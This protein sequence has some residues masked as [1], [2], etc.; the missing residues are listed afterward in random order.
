MIVPLEGNLPVSKEEPQKG[1]GSSSN[2]ASLY[3]AKFVGPGWPT[4]VHHFP[5]ER[6][7]KTPKK[8]PI[9]PYNWQLF[10]KISPNF[11]PD[12]LWQKIQGRQLLSAIAEVVSTTLGASKHP[13][14]SVR[15]SQSTN[16]PIVLGAFGVSST[17]IEVQGCEE[18]G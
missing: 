5:Y 16:P 15:G 1:G 10:V 8:K 9:F 12:L 13:K 11:P 3:S 18:G 6:L 4:I 2:S 7:V 14:I 17:V